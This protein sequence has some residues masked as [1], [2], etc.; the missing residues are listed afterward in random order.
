MDVVVGRSCAIGDAQQKSRE[1]DAS[2]DSGGKWEEITDRMVFLMTR[3]VNVEA[4]LDV[5][6][7]VAPT[8]AAADKPIRRGGATEG[9]G[10]AAAN[11]S[12]SAPN[13]WREYYAVLAEK[14]YFHPAGRSPDY[15][16]LAILNPPPANDTNQR[17]GVLLQKTPQDG[18]IR[19]SISGC[20]IR[21]RGFAAKATAHRIEAT[22]A[23]FG[24]RTS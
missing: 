17:T 9:E 4:A 8:D 12:A 1:S 20:E 3:L 24:I 7:T 2:Q 10:K 19:R 16:T 15:H 23:R 13:G 11:A 22:S 6:P 5:I 18:R 14:F 21:C